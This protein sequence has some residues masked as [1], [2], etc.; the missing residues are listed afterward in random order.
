ML[1]LNILPKLF[2]VNFGNLKI[3]FFADGFF[4][5]SRSELLG[6]PVS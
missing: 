4:I 3:Y 6:V 1:P 2:F 5:N